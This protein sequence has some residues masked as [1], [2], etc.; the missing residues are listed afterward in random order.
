MGFEVCLVLQWHVDAQKCDFWI[1]LNVKTVLPP[2]QERRFQKSVFLRKSQEMFKNDT[3]QAALG[4]LILRKMTPGRSLELL[5]IQ[6]MKKLLIDSQQVLQNGAKFSKMLP[7]GAKVY[8][9]GIQMS[10]REPEVGLRMRKN[11][12]RQLKENSKSQNYIHI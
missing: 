1:V 9:K 12:Q 10:P 3:F 4:L 5:V 7:K 6:S 8:P 2:R 11:L